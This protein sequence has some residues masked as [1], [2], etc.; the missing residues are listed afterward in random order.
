MSKIILET[1]SPVH[2]G[3][4][5]KYSSSEFL[6]NSNEIIRYDLNKLFL[7]LDKKEKDI[8]MEYLEEQNFKLEDFVKEKKLSISEAKIYSLKSKGEIP[9]EIREHIK[10]GLKGYIPGSSLK[11]AIR[12]AILIGF[13]G[14]NEVIKIGRIFSLKNPHKRDRE[15]EAF[16]DSFFSTGKGQSSYS[17]FM[18]FVQISD[19]IPVNNLTV[20]NVQ[21]LKVIENDGWD[22]YSRNGRV[23]KSYLETIA[24]GE[25]LEGD[26]KLTYNEKS[27]NSLGLKGKGAIL[28]INEIKRL[29]YRFSCNIIEHEIDFSK[30]YG[31][32]F[33]QKFYENLKK[34]NNQ[35]SP[36]IKLGQGSGFLATTIGLEIKNYPDVY[37]EVRKSTR[38]RSYGFE[39][40]K[41]RKIVVEEKMPLGWCRLI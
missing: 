14:E 38:G 29:V 25:H 41:T 24:P 20:Y 6:I 4:G 35:S 3:S 28:D 7:F 26:I 27:Y 30:F 31:I 33:L 21:S 1:L 10:T 18:R 5:E 19:F 17:D 11:G 32:D 37:D 34:I 9:N 8:F 13:I 36:V 16:I 22:W 39:F 2:I 40:P 23:V 15:V 12:T